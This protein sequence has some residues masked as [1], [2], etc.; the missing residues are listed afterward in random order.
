[1]CN[2]HGN[3]R[4]INGVFQNALVQTKEEGGK[5]IIKQLGSIKLKITNNVINTKLVCICAFIDYLE[6]AGKC[7]ERT[8]SVLCA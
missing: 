8:K 3:R 1:M 6:V 5:G 4:K 2:K 7:D